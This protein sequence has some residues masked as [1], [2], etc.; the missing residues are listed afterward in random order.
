LAAGIAAGIEVLC[1]PAARAVQTV[2]A[3]GLGE[4][5]V[6]AELAECDFGAWRGRTLADLA[7]ADAAGVEA[8]M[9]DADAAPHGGESLSGLIGRT[10]GWLDRQAE[11]DGG[12][13]AVTHGGVIKALVVHALGAPV[14]AF[15]QI[16]VTPLA[17]TELRCDEGRWTVC[18][19]NR[20]LA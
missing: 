5:R 3:A 20:A 8:W 18:S 12:A 17:I 6:A 1:S 16:D 9:K 10:G 13:V 19:L 11:L 15:W 14:D 2:R 7:V 4:P